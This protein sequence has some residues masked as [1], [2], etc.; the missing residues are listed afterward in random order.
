M[1]LQPR[2]GVVLEREHQAAIAAG[3]LWPP[4]LEH[5]PDAS[6]VGQESDSQAGRLDELLG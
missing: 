3:H 5:E 2:R 6:P 4:R 1:P